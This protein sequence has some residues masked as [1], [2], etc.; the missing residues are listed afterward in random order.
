MTIGAAHA[1]PAA[2]LTQWREPRL[3]HGARPAT[4]KPMTPT[5]VLFQPLDLRQINLPNRIVV[6]PMCQY[7]AVDGCA[8]PWHVVHLGQLAQGGAGLL[9]LEATAVE[10]IGRITPGDLG[11]YDDATEAALDPVMKTLRSLNPAGRTA[12]GVQVGHAGRKASSYEPWRSGM[13]ISVDQGGWEAVAPSALTPIEGEALPR[14][15]TD[16]DL[17]ALIARFVDTT[18]RAERLGFDAL[19]LHAAHGYLLHQ[20]LSPLANARTDDWGGSLENRMRFPLAVL[21]AMRAAWPAHKPLGVRLSA[22][23]WVEDS[24]WAIEESTEFARRC[25]ALGADWID[26]SSGGVSRRQ[27]IVLGP[28]YQVGFAAAIRKAVKIPV[29]AVGLITEATQAESI[30]A[31]GHADLVAI[32]RAFLYDP[33]WVWH[34]ARTLGATIAAPPQYWRSEPQGARGLFGEAKIGMR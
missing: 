30:L 16:R 25:E 33:R 28:G 17:D 9:L 21:S 7:S 1:W 3:R 34:A 11:L 2:S 4:F 6:S 26:V 29:M 27:K 12:I 20:F 31:E 14:V 24:S 5:P 23:D 18:V 19:E 15:L 22:T 32:A 10:P 13:Q 8:Q